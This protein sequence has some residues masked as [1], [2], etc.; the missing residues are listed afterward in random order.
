M[1]GMPIAAMQAVILLT[2]ALH[3]R[4]SG[5]SQLNYSQKILKEPAPIL[6]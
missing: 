1:T 6:L 4:K 2:A 5:S 3:G